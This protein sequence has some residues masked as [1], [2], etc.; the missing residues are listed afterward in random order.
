MHLVLTSRLD[1]SKENDIYARILLLIVED[2]EDLHNKRIN[3]SKGGGIQYG[4]PSA[5]TCH[6]YRLYT[7]CVYAISGV[8]FALATQY[9]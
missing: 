8:L 9:A 5:V 7:Y 2:R 4:K 3:Y 6:I 1:C